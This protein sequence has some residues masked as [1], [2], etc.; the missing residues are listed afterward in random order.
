[1]EN[2]YNIALKNKENNKYSEALKAFRKIVNE[3]SLSKWKEKAQKDIREIEGILH[4]VLV[5]ESKSWYDKGL[6][7]YKKE[8]FEKANE[9][10]EKVTK[11]YRD[12]EWDKK[13]QVK[14]D[15]FQAKKIYE[16]IKKEI[17]SINYYEAITKFDELKKINGT[18]ELVDKIA[19][20]LSQNVNK[21]YEA[22]KRY[23]R[24]K[25]YNKAYKVYFY[26][27]ENFPNTEISERIA[28]R[29]REVEKKIK[30]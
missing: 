3:N 23:T 12:T 21:I 27:K 14:V 22:G 5:K 17:E 29:I 19:M 9:I 4:D 11:E 6:D 25:E 28:D 8:E 16:D 26:I 10:F 7:L 15:E 1:M 18:K 24:D 13:A 20:N 2:D 30:E